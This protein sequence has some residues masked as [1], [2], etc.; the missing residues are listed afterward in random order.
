[1]PRDIDA[2]RPEYP[3]QAD[4]YLRN[5]KMEV[6]KKLKPQKG[7]ETNP[8]RARRIQGEN[9]R[10]DKTGWFLEQTAE[11]NHHVFEFGNFP[12]TNDFRPRNGVFRMMLPCDAEWAEKEDPYLKEMRDREEREAAARV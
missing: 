2:N 5:V 12:Y 10:G 11:A 6:K 8:T 9:Y 1:M 3:K 4:L 7:D